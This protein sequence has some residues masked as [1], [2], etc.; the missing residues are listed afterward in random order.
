MIMDR[1]FCDNLYFEIFQT[2][3]E[4]FWQTGSTQEKNN[5]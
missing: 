3:S 1:K 5:L 4:K 2:G